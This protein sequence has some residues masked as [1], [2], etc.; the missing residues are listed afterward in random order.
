MEA[1]FPDRYDVLSKSVF[2]RNL[3][4]FVLTLLV[5][6]CNKKKEYPLEPVPV[7]TKVVAID[8][9]YTT[10]KVIST[11]SSTSLFCGKKGIFDSYS[12]MKF[13]SIPGNFDSLFLQLTADSTSVELFLFPLKKEW[14][15]DSTYVWSDIGSLIDTLNPLK[16][17]IVDSANPLIFMGDSLSLDES[18]INE[19]NNYGLAVH[20][21]SFYSFSADSSKLKLVPHDTLDSLLLCTEDAYLLKN[22]FQ[23]SIFKDSLLVGRGLSVRTHIFIPQDSLPMEFSSIAKAE[24]LFD[25]VDSIPFSVWAT[26]TSPTLFIYASS[27]SLSDSLKFDITTLLRTVPDDNI[28]L[29]IRAVQELE[30]I[31]IKSLGNGEIKFSWV[32]FP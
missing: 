4:L 21:N 24:I 19:I 15:E 30:G 27:S 8:S 3:I 7:F 9:T 26:F 5:I 29:E 10:V 20:S 31:D 23:D 2:I 1:S 22:P 32:E 18:I 11:G 25:I 6:G 17:Y 28:C 13:D 12:L 16:S 14:F